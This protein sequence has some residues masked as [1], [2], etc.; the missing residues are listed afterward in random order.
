LL[1]CA[2]E[3]LADLA[4]EDITTRLTIIPAQ[5]GNAMTATAILSGASDLTIWQVEADYDGENV[6]EIW[7]DSDSL[8]LLREILSANG[9]DHSH[10]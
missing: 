3:P 1:D 8:A 7:L 9:K 6:K 10:E 5:E 4:C 2:I